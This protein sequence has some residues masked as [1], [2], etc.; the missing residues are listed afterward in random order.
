M[1]YK[2]YEMELGMVCRLQPQHWEA[3]RQEYCKFEASRA[4]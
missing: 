2:K 3:E 4:K 1:E